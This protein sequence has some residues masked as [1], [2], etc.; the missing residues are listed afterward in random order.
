[1]AVV[2]AVIR[3]SACMASVAVTIWLGIGFVVV[4]QDAASSGAVLRW[5]FAAGLL[6]CTTA[7]FGAACFALRPYLCGQRGGA[8]GPDPGVG[9]GRLTAGPGLTADRPGDTG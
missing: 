9:P 2:E 1:M 6:A 4:T 7:F 5:L 3:F 8:Q